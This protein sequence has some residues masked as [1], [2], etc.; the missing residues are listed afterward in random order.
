MD[1]EGRTI[2]F[3]SN[4]EVHIHYVDTPEIIEELTKPDG[5]DDLPF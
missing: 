1:F 3:Q 5:F 2:I 4:D